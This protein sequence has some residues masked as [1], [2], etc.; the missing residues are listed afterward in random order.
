MTDEEVDSCENW[1]LPIK[2]MSLPVRQE[3]E[4]IAA[5]VGGRI[6]AAREASGLTLKTL[7]ERTGLSQ[8]FLSR[9]ERGHV[10]ASIANI[11]EIARTLGLGVA[12]LLEGEAPSSDRR[13]SV[14]RGGPKFSGDGYSFRPLAP[15]MRRRQMDAFVLDFPPHHGLELTVAHE[16]EELVFVLEGRIR[17]RFGEEEVL[18]G[19]GDAVQFDSSLPHTATN[20]AA[21]PARLLMV[22]TPTRAKPLGWLNSFARPANTEPGR[23]K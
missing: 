6:R 18:L 7:A 11:L 20:V 16:G 13:W 5:T 22:T 21:K 2:Q 15:E 10:S 4:A 23:K 14:H 12:A 9:L 3:E 19:P 1:C 8:P 17:F